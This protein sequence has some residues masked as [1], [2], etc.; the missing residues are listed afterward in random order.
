[1][2]VA[3]DISFARAENKSGVDRQREIEYPGSAD[4]F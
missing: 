4:G 2:P 3:G 1:M